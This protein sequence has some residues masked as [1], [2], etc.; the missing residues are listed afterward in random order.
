MERRSGSNLET[1][2]RLRNYPLLAIQGSLSGVKSAAARKRF[3][4]DRA[5]KAA[6]ESQI[7]GNRHLIL[8]QERVPQSNKILIL[9]SRGGSDNDHLPT[10]TNDPFSPPF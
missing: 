5:G 10:T 3:L 6:S 8:I 7:A 1:A 4:F 2:S 9:W